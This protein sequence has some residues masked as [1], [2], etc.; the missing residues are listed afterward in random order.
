MNNY[1]LLL[2]Y[3]KIMM[4]NTYKLKRINILN[5]IEY[6]RHKTL[7]QRNSNIF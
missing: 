7:I 6:K 3:N 1:Y 2:D 5:T 4:K